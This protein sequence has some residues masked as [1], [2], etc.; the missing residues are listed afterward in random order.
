[1]L[2]G[3][4][5]HIWAYYECG[6]KTRQLDELI[7]SSAACFHSTFSLSGNHMET[8]LVA[9]STE[10]EPWIKFRPGTTAQSPLMV[11]G[12]ADAGSVVPIMV[13]TVL[14]MPG[15]PCHTMGTTGPLCMYL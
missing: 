3:S 10:S 13:R 12:A 15:G 14:M 6:L 5:W 8:S 9:E 11:P 1:M 7:H 4:K 2:D